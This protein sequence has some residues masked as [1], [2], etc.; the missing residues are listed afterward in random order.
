MVKDSHA[1]LTT[2]QGHP[3][4]TPLSE[5]MSATTRCKRIT[6]SLLIDVRYLIPS[7]CFSF[8]SAAESV[9]KNSCC[10][11][12]QVVYIDCLVSDM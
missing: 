7:I 4:I 9:H 3:I 12:D 8:R 10:Y 2:E 11:G 6:F 5:K 1:L